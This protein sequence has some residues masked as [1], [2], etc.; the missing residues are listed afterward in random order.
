M[1]AK[2]IEANETEN[3]KM[4]QPVGRVIISVLHQ[5]VFEHNI[6]QNDWSETGHSAVCWHIL[7]DTRAHSNN[8]CKV[9]AYPSVR[10]YKP[11]LQFFFQYLIH[12]QQKLELLFFRN[13]NKL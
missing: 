11:H 5:T 10:K 8:F 6:L 9:F 4:H 13:D 3:K 12:V 1:F 7:F 2:S